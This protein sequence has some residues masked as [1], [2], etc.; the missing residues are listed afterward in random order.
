[1]GPFLTGAPSSGRVR[2]VQPAGYGFRK[3]DFVSVSI[4]KRNVAGEVDRTDV[5]QAEHHLIEMKYRAGLISKRI[6]CRET[7]PILENRGK[8]IEHEA[9]VGQRRRQ[10]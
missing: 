3:R 2:V 10:T 4:E 7:L 9:H 6:Y 8:G 5:T 1:M